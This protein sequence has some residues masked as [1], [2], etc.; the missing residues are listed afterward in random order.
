MGDILIHL[1]SRMLRLM[2]LWGCG[3]RGSDVHQIHRPVGPSERSW[4]E[5]ATLG[6]DVS[7]LDI[8]VAHQPVARFG[9]DDANRFTNQRFANKDQF[10][11]P[12]DLAVAAHTADRD[13]AAVA[14]IVNPVRV[15]PRRPLVC[16]SRR[17]LP[18][19]LVWPLVVVDLSK[20][21][22]AP[23]L[24][25]QA[26]CRRRCGLLVERAVNPLV[27]P[28][29][30]RLAGDDPLGPDAELDPP[31]RQPRQAATPGEA[32]GGPLSERIA[33]GNPCSW[34]AASK[35]G[36]TCASSGRATA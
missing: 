15:G 34:N 24:C 8:R 35:I 2:G 11:G 33:S 21:V 36:R 28:V 26:F 32:K 9:L 27:T 5:P 12:F 1:A 10:A 3:N 7:E 30:L 18:Q 4:A 13:I 20:V 14:R 19:R 23:L 31:H 29:L 17:P 16:R 25:R 6:V 22:E